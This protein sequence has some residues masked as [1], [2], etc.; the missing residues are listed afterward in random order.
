MKIEWKEVDLPEIPVPEERPAIPK[1]IFESRCEQAYS[2]AQSDW[3]VVYGDR[4]HSANLAFLTNFDPRF[5]EAIL[6]LGPEQKRVLL[7]GNEGIGYASSAALQVEVVLYQSLSLL[8]QDR[9]KSPIL[10][11]LLREAGIEPGQR[12]GV[13]G[14][15]YLQPK[16]QVEGYSGFFIPS[17]LTD[18][19]RHLAGDGSAV[20]DATSVLMHAADGLRVTNDVH[21]VAAFEWAAARATRAIL[22]IVRNS[23]PGMTEYQAVTNMQYAGEPLSAHVMFASGRDHIVGLRSPS[24]RRIDRGDGATTAIGYWGGLGCRAGLVDDVGPDFID[25]LAIPYY[26]AIVTWYQSV[27]IGVKGSEIHEAIMEVLAEADLRPLL[28][29]G[30]LTSLD[31]WVNSPI[32]AGSQET[33]RSGM[34]FQCDIIPA[35]LPEGWAVNCEDPLVF[36]DDQLRSELIEQYPEVWARIQER[37]RFMMDELGIEISEEVLPLS[38]MPAYLPPLW[39]KSECGLVIS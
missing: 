8:G 12:I 29:S 24:G 4:E 19:L 13:V 30:H 39:L 20:F 11:E 27:G 22:N 37:R 6:L 28:N 21:Q 2:R 15:K 17:F 26:R 33:I 18:T 7:V 32:R 34:A 31:E 16:E 25:R 23:R 10:S 36:A 38:T 5:E 14:W 1:D 35:P 3:L 9:S